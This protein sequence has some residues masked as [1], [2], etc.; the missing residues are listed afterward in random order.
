MRLNQ[1]PRPF[2]SKSNGEEDVERQ[3][4]LYLFYWPSR[5]A[6]RLSCADADQF[7]LCF[8]LELPQWRQCRYPPVITGAFC[9]H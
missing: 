2:F 1:S 9:H 7:F 8:D 6:S 5:P 4:L 3:Q